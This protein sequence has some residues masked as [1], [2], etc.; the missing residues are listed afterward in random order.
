MPSE[1]TIKIT[2]EDTVMS[3]KFL[4]YSIFQVSAEDP[5]LRGM[6]DSVLNKFRDAPKDPDVVIKIKFTMC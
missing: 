5:I 1:V 2:E 3:E 6:I 4:E